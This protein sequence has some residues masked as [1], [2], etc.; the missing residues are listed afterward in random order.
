LQDGTDIDVQEYV[1]CDP[2]Y[3]DLLNEGLRTAWT[4]DA[5]A[6]ACYG[7]RHRS[8]AMAELLAKEIRRAF[9]PES[10]EVKHLDLAA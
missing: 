7:G 3:H 6:F 2:Q 9:G 8:V 10:V 1:R 5:V 4:H